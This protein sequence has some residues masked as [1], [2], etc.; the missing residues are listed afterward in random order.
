MEVLR[1]TV[2]QHSPGVFGS[3]YDK[4][5]RNFVRNFLFGD[6]DIHYS[7]RCIES[8]LLMDSRTE[9]WIGIPHGGVGMGAIMELAMMLDNYPATSELLYPLS[10]DFRMGGSRVLTGDKVHVKVSPGEGG[11]GGTIMVNQ[12]A[13]PYVSASIR[14]RNNELSKKD[15]FIT[16]MPGNFSDLE[17]KLFPLPYYK[18]CFVCGIERSH[19]GLRRRFYLLNTNQPGK[20]IV[21][22]A[23]FDGWD[24]ES[25]YLFQRDN[26]IHPV[27][28]LAFL[29]EVM[30]WSGF[31]LSASG[32]VTVRV[33]YT[34]YRD[35]QVRERIVVFG[36]GEKVRGNAGSRLMFWAS[37]GVAVVNDNG[38]L[39]PV[40][41]AS[42]QWLGVPELTSQMKRELI[43]EDL[44][45]R[46]FILAGAPI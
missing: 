3:R 22:T 17:N 18:S 4:D 7:D 32:A 30:G 19:P 1:K 6:S 46:A 29:D 28:F 40:I 13:A 38:S 2:S 12:E 33:D 36:R 31:M 10:A 8:N 24:S 41:A 39:E 37:G 42:G 23:G 21:S 9:G 44:T 43:P 16:Y 14:F 26:I 35:V 20:I 25:F 27:A 5:S 34:F 15:H 11:T 45:R